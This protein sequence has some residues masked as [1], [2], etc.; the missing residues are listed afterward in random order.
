MILF[1]QVVRVDARSLPCGRKVGG[2]AINDLGTGKRITSKNMERISSDESGESWV[3]PPPP[4]DH[5]RVNIDG[6]RPCRWSFVAQNCSTA[7]MGFYVCVMF[8]QNIDDV[9]KALALSAGVT[10]VQIIGRS[11]DDVKKKFVCWPQ[12][13]INRSLL[14]ILFPRYTT[15]GLPGYYPDDRLSTLRPF[16]SG[17]DDLERHRYSR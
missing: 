12:L 4:G 3:V 13:T 6:N 10:H 14:L 9:L 11:T 15:N 17:S 8:R 7:K 1:S 16:L 2:V 5:I